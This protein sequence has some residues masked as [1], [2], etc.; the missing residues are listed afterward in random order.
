[1]S[2]CVRREPVVTRRGAL[3]LGLGVAATAVGAGLVSWLSGPGSDKGDE[4]VWEG[5]LPYMASALSP[6]VANASEIA[7]ANLLLH[8]QVVLA[9]ADFVSDDD[10]IDS[11]WLKNNRSPE[12]FFG[13]HDIYVPVYDAGL[14]DDYVALAWKEGMFG[15]VMPKDVTFARDNDM[16]EMVSG[17]E[18]DFDSGLVR[19]PKS[20][21]EGY[22][23]ETAH[24][25][26]CPVRAQFL[27]PVSFASPPEVSTHYTVVDRSGAKLAEGTLKGDVWDTDLCIEC[28][29]P[30]G[31]D[32][33]FD[34][35]L[36]GVEEVAHVPSVATRYF[37]DMS[38]IV[39]PMAPACVPGVTIRVTNYDA[40]SPV[41]AAISAFVPRKAYGISAAAMARYG[42]GIIRDDPQLADGFNFTY[43][44]VFR[45]AN[46]DQLAEARGVYDR[47]GIGSS[48]YSYYREYTLRYDD[49]STY[50]E[51]ESSDAT[52]SNWDAISGEVY[53]IETTSQHDGGRA[54][55]RYY[56]ELFSLLG[57]SATSEY[58]FKDR[59]YF[60][61]LRGPWD[62]IV[63]CGCMHQDQGN[64]G[65][66][67]G[68]FV[69]TTIKVRVL[70]VNRD[71][72]DP[73]VIMAFATTEIQHDT[74]APEKWSQGGSAIYKFGLELLGHAK[75]QKGASV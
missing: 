4:V 45:Y 67:Y 50:V 15:G 31:T 69:N 25:Q 41:A 63:P 13:M 22:S 10:T 40:P 2:D 61:S 28:A 16:A 51:W 8:V 53:H 73:Y 58:T 23:Y 56:G 35:I 43:K 42:Y 1:M 30:D 52:G 57:G 64:L 55:A 32:Y 20:L 47:P 21:V 18:F 54:I 12:A 29:L 26:L 7:D 9:D 70:K 65:S 6:H 71:P 19:I 62:G 24:A 38:L 68:E 46:Q 3:A 49:G 59:E 72:A 27:L 44:G 5:V 14:G 48:A 36:D 75:V 66:P 33:E 39:V 17:C 11:L 60:A 34:V 74:L 37:A